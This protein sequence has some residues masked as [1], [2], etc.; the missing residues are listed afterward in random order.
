MRIPSVDPPGDAYG[1]CAELVEERAAAAPLRGSPACVPKGRRRGRRAEPRR[2][3]VSGHGRRATSRAPAS[4]F[5]GDLDVVSRQG[6]APGPWTPER[7]NVRD[8]RVP[9]RGG[10]RRGRS[11]LAAAVIAVRDPDRER[12][13]GFQVCFGDLRHSQQ[14]RS[15]AAMAES[16]LARRAKTSSPQPRST[17]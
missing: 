11:R 17:T 14:L 16:G 12:G 8:S 9:G 6:R 2:R 10:L 5:N 7:S 4:T 3:D 15:R 1:P 13:P